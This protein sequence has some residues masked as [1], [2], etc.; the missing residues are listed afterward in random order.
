MRTRL[1]T[2]T[3][4]SLTALAT[5]A[6]AM[7]LRA[8]AD[9][10]QNSG[11]AGNYLQLH[12]GQLK[13][14]D[15]VQAYQA[16]HSINWGQLGSR[17]G[18][19]ILSQALSETPLPSMRIEYLRLLS[20][21]GTQ[22]TPAAAEVK[23]IYYDRSQ[24]EAVRD[25][26]ALAAARIDPKSDETVSILMDAIPRW[27]YSRDEPLAAL[28]HAGP[29][30]TKAIPGLVSLLGVNVSFQYPIFNALGQ[31]VALNQPGTPPS[32]SDLLSADPTI[33]SAAFVKI[34]TVDVHDPV[35]LHTLLSVISSDDRILYRLAAIDTLSRWGV[36]DS[37]A[38]TQVLLNSMN[39][40]SLWLAAVNA[41]ST[42][43]PTNTSDIPVLEAALAS[44]NP[45]IVDAAASTLI[46]FGDQASS[47][48][49]AMIAVFKTSVANKRSGVNL[50]IVSNL[51]IS[52]HV[53]DPVLAQAILDV[54]SSGGQGQNGPFDTSAAPQLFDALSQAGPPP[55]AIKMI[56]TALEGHF[57]FVYAP[58]ARAAGSLGPEAVSLVPD[59]IYCLTPAV[60]DV[61]TNMRFAGSCGEGG[62]HPGD[63][64]STR[65]EVILALGK[66][67]PGA[68]SAVPTL[69]HYADMFPTSSYE[70]ELS[71][72]AK[73]AIASITRNGS[74]QVPLKAGESA[75]LTDNTAGAIDSKL[76]S[77]KLD[78][79]DGRARVL[80]D[81]KGDVLAVIFVGTECGGVPAYRDRVMQLATKYGPKGL[82]IVYVFS[83]VNDTP[84]SIANFMSSGKYPWPAIND[85]HQ[86]LMKLC[87]VNVF[88]ETLLF[89]RSEKLRYHGRID[90]SMFNP[91]TVQHHDLDD[92][93][94]SVM[95]G[96]LVKFTDTKT[97]GCTIPTI[98][99]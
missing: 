81:W 43:K 88:T 98:H 27:P 82:K 8:Y 83:S 7:N 70:T 20:T 42:I 56:Q 18:S 84:A 66:I 25:Q 64:T 17:K 54:L 33:A 55:A 65:L 91:N 99:S 21:Y 31:I 22:G 26:A 11:T 37:P 41:L 62:V 75:N 77:F 35:I 3:I 5:F 69:R 76:A 2:Y 45:R 93:I 96:S 6:S 71:V 95:S 60:D 85:T 86:N 19:L 30:A 39:N 57:D 79:L 59:L 63:S 29:A 48:T 61:V 28:V 46:T 74:I 89:D 12:V 73:Q 14:N 38:S 97:F 92:A 68:I 94:Q 47:A 13:S 72:A 9:T 1:Q 44:P 49:P 32:S 80:S 51:V 67:G 16:A 53:K 10:A 90:D 58:A 50:G 40:R 23:S 15:E 36:G 52:A 87:H 78:D 4:V 34:R 24:P